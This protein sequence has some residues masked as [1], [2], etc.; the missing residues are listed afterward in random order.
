M[1]AS[2]HISRAHDAPVHVSTVDPSSSYFASGSAD[3]V[4]K[5]WDLHRGYVT[6]VFKGHGGVVSALAFHHL[7]VREVGETATFRLITGSVDNRIRVFD[8]VTSHGSRG[9]KPNVVLEGH[10]SVPRGIAVSSDGKWLLSGGRDAVALI[11][12]LTTSGKG[13]HASATPVK[14]IP[15]L[16]RVEAVGILESDIV[17]SAKSPSFKFYTGGEGGTIKIWDASEGTLVASMAPQHAHVESN[18]EI[19]EEQREIL[20]VM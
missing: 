14:T 16:E 20:N 5:V 8:L 10:V 6:H 7:P 11:W 18:E 2:R 15:T 13:K 4:V 1:P 3:G 17:S 12:D 9:S 19:A